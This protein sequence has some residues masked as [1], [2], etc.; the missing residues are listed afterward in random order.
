MTKKRKWIQKRVHNQNAF[1]IFG[2]MRFIKQV[3]F[4]FYAKI[5]IALLIFSLS[6]LLFYLFNTEIFD[7]LSLWN[8]LG[9]IRFDLMTISILYVPF[10]LCYFFF[11]KG[12]AKILKV[13][14]HFSNTIAIV[15]NAIDIEYYKFTLK[16]TTADLFTTEGMAGDVLN[17]LPQFILDFWYIGL[18]IAFLIYLSN[19]LY[20]KSTK[21][22]IETI[23]IVKVILVFALPT[24]ILAGIASRGGLQLRPLGVLA[25]SQYASGKNAPIVLNTPFTII[26]SS[27]KEDLKPLNFFEEDE[28]EM[29]YNPIQSFKQ[30]S[31]SKKLNVVLIIAE[32]FSEEYI[33]YY[34]PESNFTPFLD[35]LIDESLSFN[36]MFANGKKSIEALPAIL[37][38][39]P[40]LMNTSY[41]SSKYSSNQINSLATSLKKQ[42]YQT[43]FYHGGTNGTMGFNSF[44]QMAGFDNYV[45]LNEYPNKEDYDGNWGIFDEP[46]LQFCLRDFNQMKKPFFGSIFTLSSHHPYTIPEKYEGKFPKGK[47]PI[48]QAVAYTDYALKQFFKEAEKQ[49][50]FEETI[51]VITADHTSTNLLEEYEGVPGTFEIPLIFYSP[52]Y[53]KPKFSSRVTQQCDIYPSIIDFLGFEESITSFGASVFDSSKEGFSI[54]YLSESYQFFS[55]DYY[56]QFNGEKSYALYNY[57]KK[58]NS[59]FN[60]IKNKSEISDSMDTKLKA[61]LQQYISRVI[62]NKMIERN[63]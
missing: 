31:I 10:W 21:G 25:A 24:F 44:T 52:K 62:E 48:L 33:G 35:S 18:I 63:D 36:N 49:D 29:I 57:Q 3:Y 28:L 13:L 51:F 19:F 5:G 42:G 54:N 32:S 43:A 30:E 1:N 59:R 9:G 60:R 12:K 27:Y 22:Q 41:I 8:V 7:T 16:R 46:F 47:I 58:R 20:N 50:W 26:K 37:A 15:L 6:R 61:I 53:I 39:I 40:S 55:G 45:G 38:G 11:Y 2:A 14:F 23:P 4:S 56:L 34:N 17:L